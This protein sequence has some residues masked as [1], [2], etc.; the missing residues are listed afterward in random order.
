MQVERDFVGK[1]DKE[2]TYG[3]TMLKMFGNMS[4]LK[5]PSSARCRIRKYFKPLYTMKLSEIP[6]HHKIQPQQLGKFYIPGKRDLI[7]PR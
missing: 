6:R 3:L 5:D 1:W 2:R 4:G 7:P